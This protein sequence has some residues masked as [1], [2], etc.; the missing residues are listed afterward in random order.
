[1]RAKSIIMQILDTLLNYVSE[2]LLRNVFG[3]K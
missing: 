3:Y 1:M 2:N